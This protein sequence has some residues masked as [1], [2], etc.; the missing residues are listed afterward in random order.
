MKINKIIGIGFHKT[1][2]STLRAVFEILNF[3]VL[4]PRTDLANDIFD[5][6][7]DKVFKLADKFD[8]LEDNP[9]AVIYKEL[10]AQYPGSKF[11]MTTRDENKWIKSVVNHFGGD[12]T[13]MREYIYGEG[14]GDPEN[15]A[16]LYL[17]R[18]RRHIIEVKDYFKDRPEDLL[19]ISWEQGHGWKEICDFLKIN[20]P[21]KEFP[22]VNKGAY[23][24]SEKILKNLKDFLRPYLK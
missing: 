24:N 21:K 16:L 6:N 22:H 10:D 20:Q 1:G 9:W 8:V 2:T 12:T 5:A 3:S 18:Y 7:W 19:I 15:L 11:I 23:T 13:R 14:N 17:E 4:G